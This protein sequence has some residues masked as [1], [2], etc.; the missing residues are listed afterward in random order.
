MLRARHS[1]WTNHGIWNRASILGHKTSR[2]WSRE[3]FKAAACLR[4]RAFHT[5]SKS[6]P[7]LFFLRMTLSTRTEVSY[8]YVYFFPPTSTTTYLKLSGCSYFHTQPELEPFFLPRF[9]NYNANHPPSATSSL[10]SISLLCLYPLPPQLQK[11]RQ[12]VRSITS[13]LYG[14]QRALQGVG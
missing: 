13:S 1:L 14:F 6:H 9:S 3:L 7:S 10:S 12:K 11:G 8:P 2:R 4:G 5:C